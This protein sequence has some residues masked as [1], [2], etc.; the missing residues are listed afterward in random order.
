MLPKERVLG[1][2]A[3]QPSRHGSPSAMPSFRKPAVRESWIAMAI[4]MRDV[5]QRGIEKF[6]LFQR[7][8]SGV[9]AERIGEVG[10]TASEETWSRPPSL[11]DIRDETRQLG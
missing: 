1:E 3:Q 4:G 8:S 5:Q 10:T 6:G 2:T 7:S 9:G 11:G